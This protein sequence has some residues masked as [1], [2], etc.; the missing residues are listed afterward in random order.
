[1]SEEKTCCKCK[2]TLP[3]SKF[4]KNFNHRVGESGKTYASSYCK[5][6]S[7]KVNNVHAL[8]YL[9]RKIDANDAFR[10]ELE[11]DP[12]FRDL[13]IMLGK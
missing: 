9:D 2:R 3:L 12:E 6:C 8:R 5:E 1:M 10:A 13:M 4:Y 11:Q 7:R